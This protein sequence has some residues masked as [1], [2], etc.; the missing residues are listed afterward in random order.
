MV[1]GRRFEKG[2]VVSILQEV[3]EAHGEISAKALE[4]E[5][6]PTST[7]YSRFDSLLDAEEAVVGEVDFVCDDCGREF[8]DRRGYAVHRASRTEER[9]CETW[10]DNFKRV[11]QE[12]DGIDCACLVYVLKIQRQCDGKEFFY[13]GRSVNP[14]ER[15]T[16]HMV[17][18]S[19]RI[20][21]PTP[22]GTFEKRDYDFVEIVRT[23][24]CESDARAKEVE[25]KTLLEVAIE[26]D[27][28]DV[29]GGR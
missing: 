15:L 13:V 5:N 28:T 20:S 21:Q 24:P 29:L 14:V 18:R 22:E 27:T 3:Y 6:V 11:E 16:Q 2:E 17:G 7:V 19:G 1:S 23:I 4:Q 26:R 12:V 25:R 9:G 10:E 8:D